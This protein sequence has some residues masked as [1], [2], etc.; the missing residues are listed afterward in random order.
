VKASEDCDV[1]LSHYQAEVLLRAYASQKRTVKASPDL[2]RSKVEVEITEEGARF[3]VG[4]CVSWSVLHRIL[5][6]PRKCFCFRGEEMEE[7]RLESPETGLILAL[8]P[9]SGAPT[10]MVSGFPMH[11]IKDIDPHRDTRLKIEAIK[12][13]RG[14]VLDTA[15]GLGYTAIESARTADH[16]VTIE[17]DPAVLQIARKNPWSRE[18]FRHPR[19]EQKIGDATVLVKEM[20]SGLFDRIIHDPPTLRIAGEMY[21]GAFYAELHRVLRRRGKMFHYVGD[22]ESELGARVYP[23]VIRRLYEAGFRKVYSVKEA[24]GLVALK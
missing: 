18:L 6:E 15:T 3:P 11:R 24:F 7:V 1:V 9:T 8:V 20:A 17:R 23:G 12:P 14:R 5:E 4:V 2:N 10:L 16:V 21:S 19:I 22:P 13:L